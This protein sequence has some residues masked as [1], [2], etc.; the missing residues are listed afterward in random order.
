[1]RILLICLL[2]CA[3]SPDAPVLTEPTVAASDVKPAEGWYNAAC[4]AS[5]DGDID[6]ALRHIQA[7][8]RAGEAPLEWMGKDPDLT[9]LR[10]DP[11]Y[12]QVRNQSLDA[13]LLSQPPETS[14]DWMKAAAIHQLQGRKASKAVLEAEQMGWVHAVF[15]PPVD[16]STPALEVLRT[17]RAAMIEERKGTLTIEAPAAFELANIIL[18]LTEY[19][20]SPS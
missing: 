1:M 11:R 2:S 17:R 10:A 9:K 16:A 13:Y 6:G 15:Q 7:S 8:I 4:Y 14:Q 19:G 12:V 18:A 3:K 5:L 20:Q